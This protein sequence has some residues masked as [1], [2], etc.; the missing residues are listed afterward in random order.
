VEGLFGGRF[1]YC[2]WT[3]VASR[4]SISE[5][6]RQI[7]QIL[8]GQGLG[9]GILSLNLVLEVVVAVPGIQKEG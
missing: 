3:M 7:S 5:V 9:T 6:L 1:G 4:C 8:V 2:F